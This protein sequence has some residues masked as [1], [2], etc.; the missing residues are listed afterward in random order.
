[1]N[2]IKIF[3]TPHKALRK[4]MAEFS[5]LAGKTD[6]ANESELQALKQLGNEM[7]D[8]LK[9]HAHIEESLVL[10]ALEAKA[11]G[12]SDE[13][14]EEH[15]QL[16]KVQAELEEWLNSF[17][18]SQSEEEGFQFYLAFSSY[19][20]QYL[21]HIIHEE[22]NTQE[23]L[24]KYLSDEELMGLQM[25]I[26]KSIPFDVFLVWCKHITPAQT[27]KENLAMLTGMKMMLP[28]PAFEKIVSM[29]QASV[30][31]NEYYELMTELG[32]LPAKAA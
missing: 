29:V 16:E 13:N 25:Q 24:W 12:S 19:H 27:R 31:A 11:P 22:T 3:S 15:E 8:L 9:E 7:F 32:K 20:G 1:M 23:L 30:S 18:G 2:K 28:A 17:D 10:T 26:L 5:L 14:I 21:E 4:L 6:Y